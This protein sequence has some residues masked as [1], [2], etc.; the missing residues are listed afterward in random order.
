MQVTPMSISNTTQLRAVTTQNIHDAAPTSSVDGKRNQRD[1]SDEKIRF[2][3][4]GCAKPLT[5]P[6]GLVG[7]KA[8]CK[9][10]GQSFLVPAAVPVS[11]VTVN[12]GPTQEGLTDVRLPGTFT[13]RTHLPLAYALTLGSFGVLIGG[14]IIASRYS[15][16]H[17]VSGIGLWVPI[18]LC[19][20]T[21]IAGL[22]VWAA[23]KGHSP[24]IGFFCGLF[25]GPAGALL[26]LLIGN[27]AATPVENRERGSDKDK[28]IPYG[29]AGLI[30]VMLRLLL[31]PLAGA[32]TAGS[33]IGFIV[34]GIAVFGPHV[35]LIF[36]IAGIIK[37]SGAAAGIIGITAW[38][39]FTFLPLAMR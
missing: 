37:R 34:L 18:I 19:T 30:L 36:S 29:T 1:I 25:L 2:G 4:P 26:L 21:Y 16:E 10:C 23:A 11:T 27:R 38:V 15:A 6:V 22:S 17:A 32:H 7:K 5:A 12:Q 33:P 39:A 8:A 20:L 3:C 24:A 13:A 31:I 28:N 14:F 35:G 9:K